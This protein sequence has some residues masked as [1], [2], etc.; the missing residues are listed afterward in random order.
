LILPKRKPGALVFLGGKAAGLS[1]VFNVHKHTLHPLI[2]HPL[3]GLPLFDWHPSPPLNPAPI[4]VRKLA[5]RYGI[6]VPH[7]FVVARLAG[8]G[9]EMEAHQ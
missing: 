6:S 1:G 4:T 5:Q 8:L 7:A 2:C 3:S 9:I